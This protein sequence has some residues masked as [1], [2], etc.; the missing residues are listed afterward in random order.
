VKKLREAGIVTGVL[1]S[2]LLPGIND[3]P[4]ALEAVASR[5]AAA[6]ASF[7]GAHPLFLKS[8]SRP[9]WMSFVREHFP[10]LVEDYTKRFARADFV[11]GEYREMVAGRVRAAC[12]KHGLARRSTDALLSSALGPKTAG[13]V[14]SGA[15][16]RKAPQSARTAGFGVPEPAQGTLFAIA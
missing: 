9:T 16:A 13:A 11:D 5:A 15:P 4:R 2:P 10:H 6:G 8:C 3:T 12:R 14:S 1:C 7:L